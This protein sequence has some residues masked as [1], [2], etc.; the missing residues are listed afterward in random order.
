MCELGGRATLPR[1]ARGAVAGVRGGAA[2]LAGIIVGL[3]R[4]GYEI[5][6]GC[7]RAKRAA[8]LIA[9][10]IPRNVWVF[11]CDHC[12]RADPPGLWRGLPVWWDGETWQV[13]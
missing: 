7:R 13:Q 3:P 4:L 11:A 6:A 12:Y 8:A 2:V 5:C 1:A 10:H 9:L